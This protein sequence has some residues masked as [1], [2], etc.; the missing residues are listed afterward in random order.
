MVL[1]LIKRTAGTP[2]ST[3]KVAVTTCDPVV[4][5]TLR[6]PVVATSSIVMGTEALVGPFTVTVPVVMSAPKFTVVVGPK[7]V[8]VPVMR[9]VSEEPWW[10]DA[11]F[12]VALEEITPEPE[13]GMSSGLGLPVLEMVMEPVTVPAIVGEN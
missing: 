4:M 1:G 6:L 10:A 5:V 3:S 2:A 7:F 12:K 11:G 8:S 9:I 13:S